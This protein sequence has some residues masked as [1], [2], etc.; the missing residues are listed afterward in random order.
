MET[1]FDPE[2]LVP[3]CMDFFPTK[4]IMVLGFFHEMHMPIQYLEPP[5]EVSE[6]KVWVL[7]RY[8]REKSYMPDNKHEVTNTFTKI[9][10]LKLIKKMF[11]CYWP[12]LFYLNKIKQ[13]I[14]PLFNS[15][16]QII[17]ECQNF[18]M[19]TDFIH[20]ASLSF[21]SCILPPI[22]ILLFFLSR[23]MYVVKCHKNTK[24]LLISHHVNGTRFISHKSKLDLH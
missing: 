12:K 23:C 10:G 9:Q 4:F 11:S 7:K 18:C 6:Q 24:I 15:P 13:N 20:S 8:R 2:I 21:L 16:F 22:I 1:H 5:Q 19:I 14:D 17:S 3:T